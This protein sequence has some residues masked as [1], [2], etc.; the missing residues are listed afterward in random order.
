MF[1]LLVFGTKSLISSPRYKL[2]VFN[3]HL[4]EGNKAFQIETFLFLKRSI[5]EEKK[6]VWCWKIEGIMVK[7]KVDKDKLH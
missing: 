7:G 6:C 4:L 1:V 5:H 3:L 2:Y